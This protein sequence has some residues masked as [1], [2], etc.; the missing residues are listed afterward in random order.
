VLPCFRSCPLQ[1]G[2]K[3]LQGGLS[4]TPAGAVLLMARSAWRQCRAASSCLVADL[5]LW[6][7]V[8]MW[9]SGA[10][11]ASREQ[12]CGASVPRPLLDRSE[13]EPRPWGFKGG[14]T[15]KVAPWEI[16]VRAPCGKVCA[17]SQMHKSRLSRDCCT[18]LAAEVPKSPLSQSLHSDV[19]SLATTHPKDPAL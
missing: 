2:R 12:G 6:K 9:I 7:C 4:S 8:E 11:T 14:A 19:A 15:W 5:L 3:L 18:N 1:A 13:Q 10:K 17:P 16:E